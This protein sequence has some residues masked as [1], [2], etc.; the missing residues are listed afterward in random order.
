[1]NAQ[2]RWQKALKQLRKIGVN[3]SKQ[4]AARIKERRVK[5]LYDEAQWAQAE[6]LG[7]CIGWDPDRD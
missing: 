1:M 3:N 2:E 6:C 7:V 5:E 4:L